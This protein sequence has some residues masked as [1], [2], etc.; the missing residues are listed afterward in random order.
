MIDYKLNLQTD[1]VGGYFSTE[2][3]ELLT[4]IQSNFPNE[5]I[6]FV[7]E[8]E[9]IKDLYDKE[10]IENIF[11][12]LGEEDAKRKVFK[13]YQASLVYHNSNKI[14]IIINDLK[15]VGLSEFEQQEIKKLALA[16]HIDI[17]KIMQLIVEN[18]KEDKDK[19]FKSSHRFVSLER[20]Q[21]KS[22][23]MFEEFLLLNQQLD[24]F[25]SITIGSGSI[26]EV[27]NDFYPISNNEEE[28]R[29]RYDFYKAKKD[30]DFA[31]KNNKQVRYHSLLVREAP[32]Y[33][34]NKSKQEI[35][36]II[37]EYVKESI[38]FINEYNE[39]H[40]ITKNDKQ[41]P[42][43]NAI[44][45]FN[46]IITFEEMIFDQNDKKWK[47]VNKEGKVETGNN[48]Y[49]DLR[50]G[51]IPEY[52]N[53]WEIMEPGI[54]LEELLS[55]FDY[56]LEN[57]KEGISYVYNEP[58]MENEKRRKKV[59]ETLKEIEI[60]KPGIIDTLGTQ[61]H[62]TITESSDKITKCFGDL[63]KIQDETGK[64]V[65]ITEFDMSLGSDDILRVF[66]ENP[67]V[68]LEQA[69]WYKYERI[70]EIEQI[71]INSKINL[72]GVSY[73][74]LTDR[75][76]SNLERLRTNFLS[77]GKI[78]NINQIPTACGGLYPTYIELL[79]QMTNNQTQTQI[80]SSNKKLVKKLNKT[81]NITFYCIL[82]IIAFLLTLLI[83]N[84]FL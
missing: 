20:D 53:M 50:E 71:I 55:C 33:F 3:L 5:L 78:T 51:E 6:E 42:V 39:T 61:M 16:E 37:S 70:R 45:L 30:L 31:Y 38:D 48:S 17:N 18:H 84:I 66:G 74:S 81:G 80:Y 9:Q 14:D 79:K 11:I 32:N 75:I 13:D 83:I 76:D 28:K 60:I 36:N 8:C 65:Q 23:Y 10:T 29:K 68:S 19:I 73:W 63:K 35:L 77:Y 34:E 4:I 58:F 47:K 25:N 27:V 67:D 7:L 21:L 26:Y 15:H 62:I 64:K 12:N 41:E 2:Q 57:K 52:K 40:K 43:I 1:I 46:E 54:S 69:Y 24:R 72:S 22:P 82:G 56:A 59:L 44:D 49:R